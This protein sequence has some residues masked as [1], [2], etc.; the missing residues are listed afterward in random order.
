MVMQ[1]FDFFQSILSNYCLLFFLALLSVCFFLLSAIFNKNKQK[2]RQ[3]NYLQSSKNREKIHGIIFG[4]RKQEYMF[5]P[6]NDEGHILVVGGSGSGK[7]SAILIPTLQCWT[8]TSLTIDISGDICKNVHMD[9]KLIY[10]PSTPDTIPYDVFAPID[11]LEDE[12]SQNEALE[13]LA[14]LLMPDNGTMSDSGQFFHTEGR[15]IL[16]AS[17]I[18]FYHQGIDFISIC[19]K[20]VSSSWQ[21]LFRSIDNTGYEKAIQY[22]NSFEGAS[23]QNTAG[24]KQACDSVLKLFATNKKIKQ[25]IRRPS[26]G[27]ESFSPSALEEKNIFLVIPDSKLK[28]YAPL[29]HLITSQCMDFFSDRS[30]DAENTIL[31]CLDEFASLGRMDIIDALRKY[32]KKHIRIIVLTQSTADIDLIYGKEERSAMLN[33]F[34]YKVVLNADD[35]DTQEYFSKLIGYS[36]TQRNSVSKNSKQTTKT[37]SDSREW[38]VEPSDLARLGDHFI[39]LYPGGYEKLEKNFYYK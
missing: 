18:A 27:E 21:V 34:K 35:T 14:F 31:F 7:T 8:G 17:L 4:K 39:L 15:K 30:N 3:Q 9:N 20:I 38:T 12:D 32:R 23:H 36:I 6:T 25:A 19:E 37:K 33:N 11:Q 13:Q 1:I 24:C 26:E 16:T 29:L 5:S 10:E 22:I 2:Q 28:L